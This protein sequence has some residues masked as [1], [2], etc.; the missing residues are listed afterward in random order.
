M[1]KGILI[2]HIINIDGCYCNIDCK[3]LNKNKC[4]LFKTSLMNLI[5]DIESLN[6]VIRCEECLLKVDELS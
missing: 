5:S 2:N 1:E 4:E 6:G 3:Y